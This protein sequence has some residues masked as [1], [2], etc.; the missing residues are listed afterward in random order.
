MAATMLLNVIT[1]GCSKAQKSSDNSSATTTGIGSLAGKKVLIVYLTRTKNTEAIAKMIQKKVGGKLTGLELVTPYPQNYR[2]QV[3]Q[4]VRENESGFLPPL[5]TKVDS[6]AAYD[7]V[8]VGFPTWDMKMPPPMRSFLKQNN[9]SGK[10]VVPFNTNAG[11]G[12]GSGFQ[13]VK[14]LC[15][16]SKVLEGFSTRGGIER[17]GVLFVM[18][19][20]KEKQA[21]KEVKNWLQNLKISK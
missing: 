19:G 12:V 13:T 21:E 11:Y 6:I 5:K 20:E 3:E 9:L 2:A 1:S 17:D 18:E 16:D 4:V 8:F 15:P 14:E 10:Y 7:V